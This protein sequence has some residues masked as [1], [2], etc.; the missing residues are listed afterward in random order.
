MYKY[1][2]SV[3]IPI[4]NVENYLS[5]AIESVI[6]Q[7]IGFKDNI[8]LILIND[9]STD[10]SE[11]ICMQYKQKYP[12]NIIYVK[13]EN[14]GVSSARN[15]GMQYIEGEYV[16]FLDGDD[17]WNLDVFELVWDF[18]KKNDVKLVACRKKYF[19]AI[20]DYHVLDYV[21]E[22][23]KIINIE[24]DYQYIHLHAASTFFEANTA[25]K[26]K[27]DVNLKYGED[28][29]FVSEI[30]IDE[31]KYAVLRNA[32]YNYRK[33]INETSILQKSF[34][35]IRWYNETI[36][37]YHEKIIEKSIKNQGKILP[38]VQYI[39]M[40]DLK[41]R[42]SKE[43]PNF[44]N[45]EQK[46]QYRDLLLKLIKNFEDYIIC[47]QKKFY[48]TEK[49]F[50]LS[51]K[52]GRDIVNDL[53]YINGKLFFNDIS[54]FSIKN[55]KSICVLKKLY[56]KKRLFIEG[57]FKIPI[58]S[59]LYDIYFEN[60]TKKYPLELLEE[61]GE[62]IIE[63]KIFS[64]G[65][66]KKFKYKFKVKINIEKSNELKLFLKFKD[67]FINVLTINK[68]GMEIFYKKNKYKLICK[69]KEILIEKKK[70]KFYRFFRR[71]F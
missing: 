3:I 4:Y 44:M 60:N 14:G 68:E 21:F 17:K 6:N 19:E 26:Y 67:S 34:S 30:L 35:D 43:F 63:N 29:K 1:K 9:G 62:D 54:I 66:K 48:A 36:K 8:Q 7:T 18:F 55:N 53:K 41:G 56:I 31:K 64:I 39:L 65:R 61:E 11:K 5:E 22:E 47:E 13:Q 32:I 45:D 57:D 33:R 52:Y 10:N 69:D 23:D 49:I 59:N 24:Q 20:D 16:N 46:R 37:N 40:Y 2:F 50:V 58:P 28:A 15:T 12:D 38:Y 42:I 71:I 25:R 51:L 70:N 27:F